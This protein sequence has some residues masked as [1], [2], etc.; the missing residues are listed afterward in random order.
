MAGGAAEVDAVTVKPCL[1]CRRPTR[2][3]SRCPA[4]AKLHEASRGTTAQRGYGGR[5]QRIAREAIQQSPVCAVC[6]T[7]QDL[8][9]DHL[10]PVSRGGTADDGV[11]V[12]C[13]RHN[14]QRGNRSL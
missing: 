9:V 2:H 7:T 3:G 1:T 13:R 8:T 12:L 11:R 6:G 10:V 14:S 5:W 4:C